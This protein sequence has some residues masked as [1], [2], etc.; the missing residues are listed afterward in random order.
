MWLQIFWEFNLIEVW[1]LKGKQCPGGNKYRN[2]LTVLFYFNMGGG[3]KVMAWK[4]WRTVDINIKLAKT[5]E[6][7][8]VAAMLGKKAA[9]RGAFC[10][11]LNTVQHIVMKAHTS[12]VLTTKY[13]K[14]H[15]ASG[16][17]YHTLHEISMPRQNW[18]RNI[19]NPLRNSISSTLG[20]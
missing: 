15:D 1:Q 7:L 16:P 19:N 12:F 2:R 17:G 4:I 5:H 18:I 6:L 14:L 13:H 9:R 3:R 10:C 11:C 8:P 20:C